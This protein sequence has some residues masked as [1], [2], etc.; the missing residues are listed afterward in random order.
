MNTSLFDRLR[1]LKLPN[2][3]YAVFGSGPLVIRDVIPLANDLDVICK[4]SVWDIVSEI[5]TVEYLP[6]YDVSVV[7]MHNGELTFGTTWGIGDF[8]VY[9]LI[10]TAETIAEL[11]FVQLK[12]VVEYKTIRNSQKDQNHLHALQV[13]TE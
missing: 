6:D 1:Q 12:Y 11:P 8:D 10:D 13:A 4:H 5:G 7:S 2:D 3:G 9:E